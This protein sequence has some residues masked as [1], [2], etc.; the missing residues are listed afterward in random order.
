MIT[1]PKDIDVV[2]LCGGRGER[3]R[4]I[5]NG[6]PKSMAEINGRPFLDILI[7]YVTKF[8]F[9]R[10]ILC[11]GYLG[12]FI[13]EYY[14]AKGSGLEIIFSEE[15]E[16]LGTGGA[17]KNAEP[18]IR[19]SP[20]LIMNGDSFCELDFIEFINF[21]IRKKGLISI[22]LTRGLD[23]VDEYGAVML[24]GSEN[25]I[26]FDEKKKSKH[27]DHFVNA[28]I[29]LLEREVISRMP[30]NTKFSLE[31]DFLPKMINKRF[32]GYKI[33]GVFIDIGT[34]QKYKKAHQLFKL[35]WG[36]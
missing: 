27:I 30:C 11:I 1:N 4:S 31:Y 22:A 2:M 6:R 26:A 25:V 13:K 28:G 14:K 18:F 34:P 5:V 9:R 15:K 12:S 36:E 3:L 21:H 35:L 8:G 16:P 23:E 7:N 29:Y 20:F 17:I 33:E 24:D 19:S 32:Y 10:F